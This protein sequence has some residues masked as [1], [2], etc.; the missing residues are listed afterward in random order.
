VVEKPIEFRMRFAEVLERAAREVRDP[1]VDVARSVGPYITVSR[2]YGSGGADVAGAV[3]RRLGWSLLDRR[4]VEELAER[5][6]VS[7][8]TVELVDETRS[9]WF[10]DTLLNL[11]EPRLA[12]E[13]N[14]LAQMAK[15]VCLA[16]YDGRVVVVGRGGNFILPR[17]RGLAVRV[18]A[19]D[20]FRVNRLMEREG[21]DQRSAE[22][23]IRDT[24]AARADFIHRHFGHDVMD[25]SFYDLVL[26]ASV[27]GVDDAADL[28]CRAAELKGLLAD[29]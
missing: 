22:H 28:V 23:A 3:A 1:T 4:L 18:D 25:P 14:Y 19:P 6:K 11:M 13:D 29:R 26:D 27:F 7:P 16:G 9:S 5:I 8:H 2:S 15:V 17:E 21:L 12:I 20:S 24:D 10:R